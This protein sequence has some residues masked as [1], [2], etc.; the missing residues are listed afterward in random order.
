MGTFKR[1]PYKK[2]KFKGA[3]D[4]YEKNSLGSYGNRK[5]NPEIFTMIGKARRKLVKG[6]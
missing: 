1:P 6:T 4:G 2:N 5:D 3:K